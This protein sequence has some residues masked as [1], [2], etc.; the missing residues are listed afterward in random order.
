M[1][2][3]PDHAGT[4]EPLTQI[5]TEHLELLQ[6]AELLQMLIRNEI[7]EALDPFLL[8]IRSIAPQKNTPYECRGV[9][10]VLHGQGPDL[11]SLRPQ[12]SLPLYTSFRHILRLM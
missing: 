11:K 10:P 8:I 7:Q 3:T 9:V 5:G 12:F 6:P 2:A 1:A 4:D